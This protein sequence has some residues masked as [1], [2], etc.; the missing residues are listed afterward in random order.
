MSIIT[1]I[2]QGLKKVILK[3]DITGKL[4]TIVD[5][6]TM[7]TASLVEDIGLTIKSLLTGVEEFHSKGVDNLTPKAI[8]FIT[9]IEKGKYANQKL[10]ELYENLKAEMIDKFAENNDIDRATAL[11]G[12][13][14]ESWTELLSKKDRFMYIGQLY[15]SI[16]LP[17]FKKANE[18]FPVPLFDS[19]IA[20]NAMD[21]I[22]N[23]TK[24]MGDK[25]KKAEYVKRAETELAKMKYTAKQFLSSN[26]LHA[27]IEGMFKADFNVLAPFTHGAFKINDIL[28]PASSGFEIGDKVAGLRH[29]VMT[30]V[31]V[32]NVVGYTTDS[33]IKID[34][35]HFKRFQADSDGDFFLIS[36]L[37]YYLI[38]GKR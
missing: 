17:T 15:K 4:R 7:S 38:S 34:E 22:A 14:E 13:I 36:D 9:R 32:F 37:I 18:I 26:K 19:F 25:E 27:F 6:E 5:R 8:I 12:R 29:P 33:T 3:L 11:V 16:L 21:Y 20:G 2:T 31:V 1:K 35:I 23:Y 28:V 10:K 30:G 24:A